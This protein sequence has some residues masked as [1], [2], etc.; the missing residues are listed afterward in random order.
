MS[1]HLDHE[2]HHAHEGGWLKREMSHIKDHWFSCLFFC[3]ISH[4]L[5]H[6]SEYI[7]NCL[8]Q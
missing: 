8:T 6:V 3:I 1:N 2:C 7:F 4:L 5:F